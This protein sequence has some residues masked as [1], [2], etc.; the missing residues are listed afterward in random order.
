MTIAYDT[1]IFIYWLDKSSPFFNQSLKALRLLEQSDVNGAVS[2]LTIT[3]L[4]AG[5]KSML[6]ATVLNSF[7]NNLILV[8][9]DSNV[10]EIAGDLRQKYSSLRTPDSVHLATALSIGA[11][12]LI[13]NDKYLL[14]LKDPGIEMTPI[15]SFSREI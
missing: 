8:P 15:M 6:D 4:R 14:N 5:M 3:E 7:G 9:V 13:T 1:N 2:V 10:A 12:K 11:Q